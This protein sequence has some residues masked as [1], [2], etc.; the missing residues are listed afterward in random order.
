S[1]GTEAIALFRAYASRRLEDPDAFPPL[2]IL[3]DVN[4]PLMGGFEFAEALS[5]LPAYAYDGAI[6]MLS[7]S[8]AESDRE[9]A[10]QTAFVEGYVVKPL[11]QLEALD[12]AQRFGT[13]ELVAS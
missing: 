9:R 10:A 1:D 7:S 5:E 13:E 6:V 3:L 2:L 11:T 4:M 8:N 12:L